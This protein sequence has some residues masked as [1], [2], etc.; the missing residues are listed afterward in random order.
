MSEILARRSAVQPA[1]AT[2]PRLGFLSVGWIGRRRM[3]AIAKSGIAEI[4]AIADPMPAAAAQAA[5]IAPGAAVMASL[6]DLLELDLDGISIA[7]PSALHAEQAIAALERGLAVFCQKPLARTADETRRVVEAARRA[8]RLLEVD[9]SY[10]F[11]S[12]IKKITE[13]ARAGAPRQHLRR[14]SYLS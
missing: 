5:S 2:R 4:S 9:L 13:L 1:T 3:E 7:T 8:D 6:S 14:R 12:G 11:T 10:R